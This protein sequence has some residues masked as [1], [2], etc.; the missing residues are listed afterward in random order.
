MIGQC[1]YS[2]YFIAWKWK[3]ACAEGKVNEVWIFKMGKA[4]KKNIV[5]GKYRVKDSFGWSVWECFSHFD[6]LLVHWWKAIFVIRNM[7]IKNYYDS[8]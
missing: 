4:K 8:I 1:N 7:S 2:S 5:E 6:A 3:L